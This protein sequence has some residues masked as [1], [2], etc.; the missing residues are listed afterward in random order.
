M[1]FEHSEPVDRAGVELGKLEALQH[2]ALELERL[3]ENL[4]ADY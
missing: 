3:N 2:I 1:R 4:E